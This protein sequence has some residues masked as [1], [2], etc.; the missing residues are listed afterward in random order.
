[1]RP[2]D[3]KWHSIAYH[4]PT[5]TL[6]VNDWDRLSSTL[7][8]PSPS[9]PLD[10]GSENLPVTPPGA[11]QLPKPAIKEA[12]GGNLLS[13]E[14]PA[15][16]TGPS[17]ASFHSAGTEGPRSAVQLSSPALDCGGCTGPPS[18]QSS[19]SG[20]SPECDVQGLP[21]VASSD[22]SA[23]SGA[24][25]GE[26]S[27]LQSG[28]EGLGGPGVCKE[29]V[30]PQ[31]AVVVEF[32]LPSGCYATML[33]REACEVFQPGLPSPYAPVGCGADTEDGVKPL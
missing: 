10:R 31:R 30:S 15:C 13:V 9:I 12:G 25:G 14:S 16:S 3:L 27:G 7:A 20:S 11:E 17:G 32:S 29:G 23:V 21:V 5:E 1:M 2:P 28:L 19:C 6:T 8:V 26:R 4:S 24:A 18:L 33:I 22:P